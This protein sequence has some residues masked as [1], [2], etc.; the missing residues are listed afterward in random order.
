M[1]NYLEMMESI[2]DALKAVAQPI[3][4]MNFITKFSIDWVL[5]MIMSILQLLITK[6]QLPLKFCLVNY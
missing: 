4:N 5:N 1:T 3:T 6:H 2:V